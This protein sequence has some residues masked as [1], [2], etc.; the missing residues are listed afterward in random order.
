MFQDKGLL[1]ALT[2][3]NREMLLMQ[4]LEILGMVNLGLYE[5]FVDEWLQ[6]LDLT[7]TKLEVRFINL[8]VIP[9][10]KQL[11]GFKSDL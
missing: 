1:E 5:R 2:P 8:T 3:V 7:V 11:T 9:H 6:V 4:V 10:L